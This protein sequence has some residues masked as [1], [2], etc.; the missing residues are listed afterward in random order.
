MAENPNNG[1]HKE[2]R[3]TLK[4]IGERLGHVE[5]ASRPVNDEREVREPT[6]GRNHA[7]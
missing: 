5:G 3:D 7:L 4:K 2:I 6:R 1:F